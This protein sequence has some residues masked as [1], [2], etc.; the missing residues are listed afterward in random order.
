MKSSWRTALAHG[1]GVAVGNAGQAGVVRV[2]RNGE[3][4]HGLGHRRP[5]PQAARIANSF[6]GVP[7]S[8]D[9]VG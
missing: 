3:G 1:H 2:G 6:A 7:A 4:C 9:D 5:G 8:A